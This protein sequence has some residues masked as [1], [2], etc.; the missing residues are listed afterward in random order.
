MKDVTKAIKRTNKALSELAWEGSSLGTIND[1]I[2]QTKNDFDQV[3]AKIKVTLVEFLLC[4]ERETLAGPDYAPILG[5]Q[6]WGAQQG[7]VYAGG[8]RIKVN[9]PRLRKE[10]KEVPL[11]VYQA[12]GDRSRFS[13][14]LLQKALSGISTRN[15]GTTLDYLLGDFG[16]SKSSVSRY[17]VAA[18]TQELKELKER[19]LENFEPFAIFL[20]GYCLAGEV[21]IVALGLNIEG[22]KQVLGFWQGATENHAICQELLDDLETRK[23]A[24]SENVIYIT[25][26]GKGI[27]KALKDRFGKQLL[28]QRCTIHKDRNIQSHLAKKYRKTAHKR[29]RNAINCHSYEDAKEELKKLEEWLEQ[30]NPSAAESLRECQEE[31]L[32]VHRLETSALLRKTLHS[33]NPIESMFAQS[34]WAQRNIKNKSSGKTMPQRWLGATLLNAEKKFRRIK[35]Y[36]AIAETRRKIMQKRETNGI[37]AA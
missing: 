32:T 6:K 8:E 24:L 34:T 18:T 23:L 13:N 3:V 9:K 10:G 28:H 17:L 26:G 11:S 22:F 20:D 37:V 1:L 36:E 19:N 16:I 30:I 35:G 2:Q 21:F 33:T 7:S 25:D 5:W 14:E 12:L 4:A 31:L 15:Y 29:F 27:I